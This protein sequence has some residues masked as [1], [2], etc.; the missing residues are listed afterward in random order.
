MNQRE[1]ILET[2]EVRDF[3]HVILRGDLCSAELIIEQGEGESLT[4]EAEPQ[5]MPRIE[6]VV[7]ERKLVIRLGGTWLERLADRLANA[8]EEPKLVLRLQLRELRS[9]DMGC[10]QHVHAT[11]IETDSLRI[12]QSGAGRLV[13]ESLSAQDLGVVQSGAGLLEIAGQVQKQ[14]VRSSGVGRYAASQL[15]SERTEVRVTGS[16][17]ARVHANGSLEAVVTGVGYVEYGGNPQV[18]TKITGAGSVVRRG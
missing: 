11:S 10:I 13:I 12:H 2:R 1:T 5:V 16:S 17:T 9:L 14:R 15:K 18:R 4:I 8:F 7:R 6:T 3:D